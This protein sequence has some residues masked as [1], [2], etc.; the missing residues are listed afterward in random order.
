MRCSL[1]ND[2]S[3]EQF[4]II[5]LI[6]MRNAMTVFGNTVSRF[7]AIRSLYIRNSSD[8]TFNLTSSSSS[9]TAATSSGDTS[10]KAGTE[11]VAGIAGEA[12]A[13]NDFFTNS[14]LR[15]LD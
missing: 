15:K 7:L 11:E 1:E 5:S 4:E 2:L 14:V 12:V 3:P 10:V 8:S 9:V 13:S 6:Y